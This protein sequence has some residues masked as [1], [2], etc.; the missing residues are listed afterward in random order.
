MIG[1]TRFNDEI[2][3]DHHSAA[4]EIAGPA[5]GKDGPVVEPQRAGVEVSRVV[6]QLVGQRAEVSQR[7]EVS[8]VMHIQ[9]RQPAKADQTLPRISPDVAQLPVHLGKQLR[10]GGDEYTDDAARSQECREPLYDI[11]IAFNVFQNIHGIDKIE[12]A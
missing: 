1:E 9:T 4:H 8:A 12:L 7:V 2:L 6:D 3:A 5:Y 10:A 11:F